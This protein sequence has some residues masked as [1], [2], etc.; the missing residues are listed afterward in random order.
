MKHEIPLTTNLTPEHPEQPGAAIS[1][2]GNQPPLRGLKVTISTKLIFM[3]MNC[4]QVM[5]HI[6]HQ[7]L[8]NPMVHECGWITISTHKTPEGA[9]RAKELHKSE[10]YKDWLDEFPTEDLQ[11]AHPFG[12]D[13][14]WRIGITELLD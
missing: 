9:E 8:Y 6:L 10:A 1:S 13:E 3:C 4:Q 11:K 2:S 7:F 12:K 14:D 5:K